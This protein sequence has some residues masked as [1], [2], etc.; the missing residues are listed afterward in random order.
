M[1]DDTVPSGTFGQESN[2]PENDDAVE[3]RSNYEICQLSGFRALPGDP[4]E[5]RDS[6][7]VE[8][9]NGLWTLRKFRDKRHP[10][11]R[12]QARASERY[13][14]QPRPEQD[15][16]FLATNEVDSEDL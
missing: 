14:P 3:V 4:N 12:Y 1:A 8:Q 13:S 15:D 2:G 6:D 5:P 7:L 10:M 11:E 9:W 16:A